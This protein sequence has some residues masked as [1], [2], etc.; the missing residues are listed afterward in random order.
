MRENMFSKVMSIL[1]YIASV[2]LWVLR[3]MGI[4]VFNSNLLIALWVL[5][6]IYKGVMLFLSTRE[7]QGIVQGSSVTRDSYNT[8]FSSIVFMGIIGITIALFY[9]VQSVKAIF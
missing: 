4:L 1:V 8:G 2:V 5:L 9:F 3:E 7:K 6:F